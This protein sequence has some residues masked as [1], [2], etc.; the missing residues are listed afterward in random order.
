MS[1]YIKVAAKGGSSEYPFNMRKHR[2]VM[3]KNNVST[4][5]SISDETL[6]EQG[7]FRVAPTP[8]PLADNEGVRV[9]EDKPTL[10][11][12]KWVQK[13]KMTKV[14]AAEAQDKLDEAASKEAK[15]AAL[16]PEVMDLFKNSTPA[17]LSV[18]VDHNFKAMGR[19]ERKFL[20]GMAL[21]VSSIV[22]EHYR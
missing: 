19:A 21:I 7:I 17:E 18:F 5:A 3:A 10:V 1:Q 2:A 15:D 12:G 8:K 6:A 13:W 16:K 4:P 22:K 9:E 14:S 11:K 20:K